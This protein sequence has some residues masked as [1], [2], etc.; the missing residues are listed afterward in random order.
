M[1]F[2]QS[3]IWKD[4]KMHLEEYIKNMYSLLQNSQ[5]FLEKLDALVAAEL[6]FS[7]L[8]DGRPCYCYNSEISAFQSIKFRNEVA[9]G[10]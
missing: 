1:K 7:G 9:R 5:I 2:L 6:G 10:V 8:S 3:E 4:Q